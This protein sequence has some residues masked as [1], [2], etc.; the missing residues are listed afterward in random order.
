MQLSIDTEVVAL[1]RAKMQPG[2]VIYLDF[3]DGDGPFA[4]TGLS[5]RLDLNFRLIIT[6]INYLAS[7]LD[8]YNETLVTA[9][10]PL[11]IKKSSERYLEENTRLTVNKALQTLQLK[12]DSGIL[13]NN[14]PI[15]RID[16]VIAGGSDGKISGC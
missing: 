6:P 13:A 2:D 12:G 4:N 8:V 11:K 3:E 16:K 5:C 15:L 10:G 9:I 7:G 1:L 14:I